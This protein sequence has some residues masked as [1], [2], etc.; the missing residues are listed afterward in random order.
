MQYKDE[1][2]L[3]FNKILGKTIKQIRTK[4]GISSNR[5]ANEYDLNSGNLSRIENG[6][7]NCK[8]I[9][10]WKISEALGL[11]FSEFAKILENE[12]GKDFKLI[13]E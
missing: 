1:K 9:S 4:K 10:I 13:D 2:I 3:Q 12:L 5:L 6:I 7:F 11:K 8:F